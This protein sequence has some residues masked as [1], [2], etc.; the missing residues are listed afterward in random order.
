MGFLPQNEV[1]QCNDFLRWCDYDWHLEDVGNYTEKDNEECLRRYG[2]DLPSGLVHVDTSEIPEFFKLIDNN[3]QNYVVVS[4]R[5]DYGP[6]YQHKFFNDPCFDVAKWLQLGMRVEHGYQDVFCPARLNKDKCNIE[7]PFSMKSWAHTLSTF[8]KIPQNVKH[9][10]VTNCQLD[11]YNVES[12]PFGVNDISVELEVAKKISS[13]DFTDINRDK[14][15]YVN[16]QFYTHE[17]FVLAQHFAPMNF[18]TYKRDIPFEEYLQD[19]AEHQFVLCPDGNGPDCYRTLEALYMGAIPVVQLSHATQ[20][21]SGLNLPIIFLKDLRMLTVPV[22][23]QFIQDNKDIFNR[24]NWD[25]S[26]ATKSYWR[27]KIE[28]KASIL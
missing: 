15:L 26:H 18:V 25:L 23:N 6:V 4:S 27:N 28:D 8:E 12:I 21:L 16:F 1:L 2:E 22:I 5:S 17:R 19:L 7:H 20:Y 13:F 10:F 9:W 14:I 3:G 11:E 24:D